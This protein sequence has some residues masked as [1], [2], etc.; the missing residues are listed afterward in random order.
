MSKSA[1]WESRA[2]VSTAPTKFDVA[3]DRVFRQFTRIFA[4][5]TVALVFFI[6]Y[7]VAGKALPAIREHGLSFLT[8]TTWNLQK[9]QFGVLP[10]I[11]GTLYSSILALLIGGFFGVSIAIFLTQNFLP[12]KVE[13]VFKNIVELLAAIPSVVYGLWGIFVVIPMIRP[14]AN[15]LHSHLGWCPLFGTSLSGPGMLP[16][17][18]VLSIMILPTV[19]AISR[20][21]LSNVPSK[22]KE[23]AYGLGATRWEAIFGVILPTAS[24]GIFGALVLGFGRALGETMALAMLVGNSNQMSVSLFS[25]GNTLAALLA[26]HFPE[27]TALE[28]PVL[29]YAALV[30]LAITLAVNICGAV[31][32]NRASARLTG[33]A[34]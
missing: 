4:W 15:W 33:V 30:L 16:A 19:T 32:L 31:V 2:S 24:K 26:N 1:E 10:E 34:H 9:G 27:A 28:E 12:S 20:G 23:A 14:V 7:E 6:V 11:W 29:M 18:L 3:N 5:L 22:L 25:P 17:A 21:S 8:S 13:W